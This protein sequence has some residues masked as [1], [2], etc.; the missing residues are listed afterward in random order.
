MQHEPRPAIHME[1]QLGW[2]HKLG[3]MKPLGVSRVGLSQVDGISDMAPA[4]WLC[5]FV[6]GEFRKVTMASAL[7]SV[8]DEAVPQLLP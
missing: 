5:G 4:C 7:L 1:K 6:G 2:A 3:G 8:W